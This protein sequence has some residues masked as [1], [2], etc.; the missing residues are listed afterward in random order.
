MGRSWGGLGRS[1]AVLGALLGQPWDSLGLFWD[2][3]GAILGQSWPWG[4]LGAVLGE[5]WGG[6][7]AVFVRFSSFVVGSS[8]VDIGHL[9]DIESDT[10]GT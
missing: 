2:G 10:G 8:M 7:A 6:L 4:G 3:L 1:W 9:S 5:S